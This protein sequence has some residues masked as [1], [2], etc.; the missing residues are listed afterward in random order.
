MVGALGIFGSSNNVK[1]IS[2]TALA[3]YLGVS[4]VG[5]YLFQTYTWVTNQDLLADPGRY[6]PPRAL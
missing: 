2:Q 4:V 6:P 1:I 5:L 3:R